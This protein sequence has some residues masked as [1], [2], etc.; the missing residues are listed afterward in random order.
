[1]IN[2]IDFG[3]SLQQ[4]G[5]VPRIHHDGSTEPQG[6]VKPMSDG[7]VLNLEPGYPQATIDALV[8]RGHR[9]QAAETAVFGGYQAIMR[10][11]ETGVYTGA[12]ERRKDGQAGGF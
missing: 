6:S 3:M 9:I 2:L 12:S 5:D 1:M 7:G 11:G 4:A 10:D 8:R